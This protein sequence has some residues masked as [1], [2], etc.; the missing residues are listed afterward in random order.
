MLWNEKYS[1]LMANYLSILVWRRLPSEQTSPVKW[2]PRAEDP[3]LCSISQGLH[4][5]HKKPEYEYGFIPCLLIK[6]IISKPPVYIVDWRPAFAVTSQCLGIPLRSARVA[7]LF[8]W[9][10]RILRSVRKA[11]V[12]SKWVLWRHQC[13]VTTKQTSAPLVTDALTMQLDVVKAITESSAVSL[14]F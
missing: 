11:S 13:A 14:G 5:A 10:V 7:P 6:K 2:S 1:D 8:K 4:L 3:T 12:T 9:T